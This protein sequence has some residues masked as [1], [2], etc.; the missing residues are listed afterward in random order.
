MSDEL[1][2]A[3]DN[4]NLSRV[5]ERTQRDITTVNDQIEEIEGDILTE[6]QSIETAEQGIAQAQKEIRARKR[7]LR[8]LA[9]RADALRARRQVFVRAEADLKALDMP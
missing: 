3:V 7:K 5:R 8:Q 1:T 9:K 6:E 4:V 2:S